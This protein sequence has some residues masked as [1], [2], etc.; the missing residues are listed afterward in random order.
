MRILRAVPWVLVLLLFVF[1]IATWSSLPEMIPMRLN[2]RGEG[3]RMVAKSFWPWFGLPIVAL[4]T[5]WLMFGVGLLLP[6][7]PELF[8]HP[9]KKRF[10]Q[11]PRAYHPP[12]ITE[13]RGLLDAASV[14]VLLT[15]LLAQWILWR[16]AMG[17]PVQGATAILLVSAALI[18][19]AILLFL[20]RISRAVDQAERAWRDAGS[21]AES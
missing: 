5:H 9:E 1:A 6:K 21:P 14:G 16:V 11:I 13:M 19:P 8:N 18:T 20:P 10:L 17:N 7:R 12:V 3:A 4:A 15:I 2:S